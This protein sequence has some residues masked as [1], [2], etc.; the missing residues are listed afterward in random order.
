MPTTTST[1]SST[2]STSSTSTTTTTTSTTT[3]TTTTTTA[4]AEPIT[5][6][7]YY[8]WFPVLVSGSF[9]SGGLVIVA[10]ALVVRCVFTLKRM[11]NIKIR[12]GTVLDAINTLTFY[13]ILQYYEI[14]PTIKFFKNFPQ[15]I[16]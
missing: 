14:S 5:E 15:F 10:V 16:Q 12:Y 6:P 11:K 2:A 3:T 8:E 1:S 7:D 4:A 13:F 9:A